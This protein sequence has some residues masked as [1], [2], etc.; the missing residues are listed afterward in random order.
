MKYEKVHNIYKRLLAIEDIDPTLVSDQ[1]HVLLFLTVVGF[2][3]FSCKYS[4]GY[5]SLS[6][7]C[8]NVRGG[9]KSR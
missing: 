3:T 6:C 9:K 8:Q 2:F 1:K 4:H 7:V 5:P